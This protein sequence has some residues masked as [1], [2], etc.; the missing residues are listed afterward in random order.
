MSK[1]PERQ[2]GADLDP[3]GERLVRYIVERGVITRR[4]PETGALRVIAAVPPQC[5][6]VPVVAAVLSMSRRTLYR[7]FRDA[8]L[9]STR[10]WIALVRAFH[11][12]AAILKGRPLKDAAAAGGYPDPF[13]MS[14]A[15]HRATGFRPSALQGIAWTQ[16]VDA[17]IARQ[18]RRGVLMERWADR[19]S[20]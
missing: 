12:H 6:R 19:S 4:G 14:N 8:G 11:T 13:T 1:D 10:D 20:E 17:W 2:A 5:L 3:T 7:L 15:I 9:P 18:Q 16:L